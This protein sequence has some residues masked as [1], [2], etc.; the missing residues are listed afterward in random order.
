VDKPLLST[1]SCVDTR[2]GHQAVPKIELRWRPSAYGI[3]LRQNSILLSRVFDGYDLPGGG[4]DLGETPEAAVVRETAEETGVTVANPRSIGAASG[5]FKFKLSDEEAFQT[6]MLYYV[7]DFVG[8]E[9]SMGGF[10]DWEKQYGGMPEWL[11]IDQLGAIKVASSHD[12][13]PLVSQAAKLD[14]SHENNWD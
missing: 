1:V 7:C 13:R 5:F 3:T 12:W 14:S 10:D 9:L 6:I 11:P 8:G 4:I 2:G